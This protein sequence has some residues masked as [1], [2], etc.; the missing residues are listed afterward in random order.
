[1]SQ[2]W[3]LSAEQK[4]NQTSSVVHADNRKSLDDIGVSN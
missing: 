1:M 3:L 2:P 4:E